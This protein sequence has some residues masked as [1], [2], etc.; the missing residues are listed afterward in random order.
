VAFDTDQTGMAGVFAGGNSLLPGCAGTYRNGTDVQTGLVYDSLNT[1]P[2]NPC[3]PAANTGWIGTNATAPDTFQTIEFRFSA[4]SAG[5]KFE[6]DADTDNFFAN[7]GGSMWGMR[8]TVELADGTIFKGVLEP[9]PE[10]PLYLDALRSEV[11]F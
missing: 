4:F 9:D 10:I 7:T 6:F 11:R 3:D 2:S 8:I 1:T 5:K